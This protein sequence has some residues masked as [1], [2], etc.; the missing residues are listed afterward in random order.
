MKKIRTSKKLRAHLS[1]GPYF[2][3]C[4]RDQ[5]VTAAWSRKLE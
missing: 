3:K 2:K 5:F 1:G 4:L